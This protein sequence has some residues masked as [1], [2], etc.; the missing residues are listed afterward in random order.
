MIQSVLLSFVMLFSSGEGT[1]TTYTVDTD[2]SSVAWV[3]K[4]VTGQHNGVVDLKTGSFE[5][6]EGKL[7]GGSFVVD[8]TSIEVQDLSGEYKGKLEGHLK[9]DDFFGAEKY[10]SSNFVITKVKSNGAGKY[11][12]TGDL[13]IKEKTE[14][15]TFPA[16]LVEANGKVTGVASLTIDRSKYD[17]KY[18]SG[19]FF[20]DLGDKTIYDDFELTVNIVGVENNQGTK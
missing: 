9:S 20:D 10:P 15:I 8:M 3:G 5:F 2:A 13:T 19:S 14:K 1:K 18:G 4:K 12:I 17:V 11:D 7:V 6:S 16:Q